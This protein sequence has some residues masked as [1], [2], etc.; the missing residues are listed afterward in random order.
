MAETRS[1]MPRETSWIFRLAQGFKMR[2]WPM[3][4]GVICCCEN[5][6][7][8]SFGLMPDFLQRRSCHPHSAGT[9]DPQNFVVL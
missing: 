4:S 9:R 2:Y 6:W 3:R 7:I 8:S 5:L 1:K